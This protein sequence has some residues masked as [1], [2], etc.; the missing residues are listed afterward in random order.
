M[1]IKEKRCLRVTVDD[2]KDLEVVG[3]IA[4]EMERKVSVLTM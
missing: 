1:N 4:K 3:E 2:A